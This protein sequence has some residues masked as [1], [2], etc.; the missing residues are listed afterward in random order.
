MKE[1][2]CDNCTYLYKNKRED[3]YFCA[4][5]RVSKEKPTKVCSLHDYNCEMLYCDNEAHYIYD[6]EIYCFDCLMKKFDV[7][8]EVTV[9]Y[10][11][12]GEYLGTDN[13]CDAVIENLYEDIEII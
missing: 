2:T 3:T 5:H 6:D 11:R 1:R 8:K 12:D 10:Y 9:S 4:K 13:D 7:E